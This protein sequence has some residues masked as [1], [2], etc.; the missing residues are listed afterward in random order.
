MLV[1]IL[2]QDSIITFFLRT[3]LPFMIVIALDMTNITNTPHVHITLL[4]L[5][6]VQP[7]LVVHI[8]LTLVLAIAPLAIAI[9]L[10]DAINH[11]TSL[12]LKHVPI[13]IEADLTPT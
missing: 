6:I 13:A 3:T 7:H 11:H 9:P 12:L 4:A 1:Q 2:A 8:N 5:I 10:L